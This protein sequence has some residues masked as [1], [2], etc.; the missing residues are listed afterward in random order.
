MRQD[1]FFILGGTL[2]V[3]AGRIV[4]IHPVVGIS[5]IICAWA[6]LVKNR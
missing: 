6:L 2:L 3:V 5:L 4:P 1:I